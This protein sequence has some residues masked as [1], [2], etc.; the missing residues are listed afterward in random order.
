MTTSYN[1]PTCGKSHDTL[2]GLRIHATRQHQL[3][4]QQLHDILYPN[5][6]S[7][8]QCGAPVKFITLQKGYQRH[9]LPCS[10]KWG[11]DKAAASRRAN[12]KPAWNHGKTKHND[13]SVQKISQRVKEAISQ[14]ECGHWNLGKTKENDPTTLQAAL[15]RSQSVKQAFKDGRRIA[16]HKGFSKADNKSLQKMSTSMRHAQLK[17]VQRGTHWS[18]SQQRQRICSAISDAQRF[19]LLTESH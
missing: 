10:K 12:Y 16:W 7:I 4:S 19:S 9:C 1:C 14:R 13:T 8:C 15:K 18:T 2:D 3:T 11:A 6:Q 5:R 17:S